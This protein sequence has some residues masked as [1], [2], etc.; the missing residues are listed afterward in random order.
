MTNKKPFPSHEKIYNVLKD[1]GIEAYPSAGRPHDVQG[2]YPPNSHDC[3]PVELIND[4][5]KE[6]SRKEFN[7]LR[8][9]R[10]TMKSLQTVV[11]SEAK[12]VDTEFIRARIRCLPKILS[13]IVDNKG[14]RTKY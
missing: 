6:S 11:D 12:K 9:S 7:L 13:A 1:A 10:K 8:S 14:G 2:G 5:L 4:R 3:I